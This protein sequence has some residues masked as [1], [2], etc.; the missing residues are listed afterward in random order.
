VSRIGD[1][2]S[3]HCGGTGRVRLLMVD[4]PEIAQGPPGRA[5]QR[6]LAALAPV[7]TSVSIE[8][9]VRAR[10]S[11][12]R[13][14]GYVYLSDGRMVNEEIARS[15]YVTALVYPPNLRHESRIRRA[16]AEARTAKRGLWATEF[17]DCSPREYRAGRC[18]N[19]G[20]LDKRR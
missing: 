17:F 13:L 7:G 14:L 9:D 11:Y 16:V 12:D 5:A 8:T 10:D 4:A 20:D 1:G 3:F 19:K 6:A 18:I 2:D 15:G